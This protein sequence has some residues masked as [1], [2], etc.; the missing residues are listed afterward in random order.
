MRLT[1]SIFA[2]ALIALPIVAALAQ[3]P[4]SVFPTAPGVLSKIVA[5]DE[6]QFLVREY[7]PAIEVKPVRREDASYD[8]PEMAA[9]A[10][11]SAMVARDFDWFRSTWDKP[12]QTIL[13]ERDAQMK[14]DASFW[15][16]T[17]ERGFANRRIELT[18]RIE[19]GVYVLIAYRLV[20][21]TEK[22]IEL[23]I[24]LKSTGGRWLA[25]QELS[26]DPVLAYW[27][28]PEVRPKRVVRPAPVR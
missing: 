8:T 3:S 9:I 14:Q 13:A 23:T 2:A 16:A 10:G 22:P 28:T 4:A 15:I 18:A 25:T 17:W 21:E 26:Q 24:V 12:S 5:E 19:T 7:K 11:I 6:Y 1:R 20:A 27:R